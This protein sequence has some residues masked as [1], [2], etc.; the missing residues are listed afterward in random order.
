MSIELVVVTPQ[1]EAFSGPVDEVVLP[2]AAGEFGVLES[3]ERFLSAID[4]G[5]MEVRTGEGSRFSAVSNGFAEVT[6]EKVVVMV[7]SL[8]AS[9]AIDV[10]AARANQ[11]AAQSELDGLSDD[12]SNDARRADLQDALARATAQLETAAKA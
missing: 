10:E 1:G 3:H 2:G 7:D 4:H 6:G 9:A 12:E 11:E 8:V 5:C